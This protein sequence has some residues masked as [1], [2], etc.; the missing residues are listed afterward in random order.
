[1]WQ[2][3]MDFDTIAIRSRNSLCGVAFNDDDIELKSIILFI[4]Y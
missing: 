3:W 4:M 1:M 2:F